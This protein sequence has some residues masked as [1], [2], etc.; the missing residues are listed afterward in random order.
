MWDMAHIRARGFLLT[1]IAFL[2][3]SC[4]LYAQERGYFKGTVLESETGEPLI[5]ATVVLRSDPTIGAATDIDGKFSIGIK[6]GQH[7]FFIRYTGMTSDTVEVSIVPGQSVERTITLIPFV[8]NLKGVEITVGRYDKRYEDLNMSLEVI[9]AELIEN[10]N[11]RNIETVLDQ[12]PGLNMLGG[13]AQIRGGSG[14]TFGVGSKTALFLD[15]LPV[16]TGDAGRPIWDF[17]PTE[18]IEQVEVVKGASSVL[19]GANALSGAIY[20]RNAY[21]KLEPLTKVTVY[22]GLYSVP[23]NKDAKWWDDVPYIVGAKFLHSRMIGNLDL[24][25][26]GSVNF[27]HGHLG[28]PVPGPHVIDTISDFSNK[29][30]QKQRARFN[31]NLR[32]RSKKKQGLSYGINGNIM[33]NRTNMVLAWLDD[34]SGFYRGYPGATMKQN[35]TMFYLDPFFNYYTQ[36][37]TRHTLKTRVFYFNNEMSNNQANRSTVFIG[38][39]QF[40]KVY[41]FLNDFEFIGGLYS[42]YTDSKA[43]L[44]AGSG[45]PNNALLNFSAY[46][47]LEL[48]LFK[49]IKI[50]FG[51]RLEYFNLNDTV[52]DLKP[53]L[54][55]AANLKLYQET[56]LRASFGQGYRYPTIAERFIRTSMGSI[57][58]FENPDL[59]PETSWNAEIGL[60]QGLKFGNYFGYIDVAVFQQEYDNT[61]EYLFGFWD[62]TYTYAIAGFKFMNTGKSRIVGVDISHTGFAK[63]GPYGQLNLTIGYTYIIPKTLE[64]DF[65]FGHDYN[66]AGNN[67]FSYKSTSVDPSNS[68]LKYRFLHTLKGDIDFSFKNWGVGTSLR[69]YSKLVNID[70]AIE[71]FEDATHKS[72]GSLQPIYYMDYFRTRNNGNFVMDIRLS[73]KIHGMHKISLVANNLLN[74]TYSLVPL[75]AEEM[76]SIVVQYSAGF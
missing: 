63:T 35:M 27:D 2:L 4:P 32:Y 62:S 19:S 13:E 47:E 41:A 54:R 56:Y 71:D 65:I 10:K 53:I 17:I 36:T 3:F 11:T 67:E 46:T 74:R 72:G 68:I 15:G 45:S 64:P 49:I 25:L 60:K 23:E 26:G 31:F 75:Q 73:Y 34:S 44:Y 7:S 28:P 52:S 24:V 5:G 55:I 29:D 16:L 14:F 22:T 48:N 69:Y 43:T 51:A 12:A 39:Y 76:R 30:M 61:I 1:L 50:N 42:H 66:P 20:I 70:K 18:N 9:S 58:V 21:P 33:K 6:P 57:A 37:G 40:R 38:D 59:K 8:S